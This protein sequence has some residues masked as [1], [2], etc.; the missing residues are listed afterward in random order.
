V[1]TRTARRVAAFPFKLACGLGGVY[2]AIVGIVFWYQT[3]GL[4]GVLLGSFLI[5]DLA[6]PFVVHAQTGRW[7]GLWLAVVGVSF[8]CGYVGA[9][10]APPDERGS[11]S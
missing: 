7:P 5:P 6:L 10:I 9:I 8:A 4:F 2:V 1:T 3:L 11:R